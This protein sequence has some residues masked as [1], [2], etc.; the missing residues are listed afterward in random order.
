MQHIRVTALGLSALLLLASPTA[1]GA[2]RAD[3]SPAAG[4]PGD[5]VSAAAA[6]PKVAP[7]VTTTERDHRRK[8]RFE[9]LPPTD[10]QEPAR[11]A[12]AIRQLGDDLPVVAAANDL[13]AAE[14]RTT[15]REDT[16]LWVAPTGQLVVK[17]QVHRGEG[18]AP[19]ASPSAPL[20]Q[21][22]SLHSLPGS[23]HTL[24]LDFDGVGVT[25]GS[26]WAQYFDL[27]A[28]SY[29]GWDPMGD[30]PG[31]SADERA[32]IADIWTRVAEDYAPFDIDVTTADPG[33]AALVRNGADDT[34]FGT[35]LV[36]TDSTSAPAALC[37][38]G[39]GGVAL[40]GQVDRL[41]P[42]G[43][44]AWVF[45]GS[46]GQSPKG[47]AE[48]AS[49]EV[50]HTFG[51]AHDGLV[52]DGDTAAQDYYLGHGTWAPIMGAAYY[53]PVTQWSN[54]YYP[55][56][57]NNERDVDLIAAIAGRRTDEGGD[58]WDSPLRVPDTTAYITA[59][60][61]VDT[62]LVDDCTSGAHIAAAV[63]GGGAANLDVDLTVAH[64]G[65]SVVAHPNPLVSSVDTP[66]HWPWY[67]GATYVGKAAAGLD[68]EAAV[69]E[70]GP[71]VV[72]V[73]SSL[74]WTSDDGRTDY[75]TDGSL[76]AYRLVVQGCS[77]PDVAPSRPTG[78]TLTVSG[79]DLVASWGAPANT[80]GQP[81]TGYRVTLN[82]K[83]AVDLGADVT[84][85]TFPGAATRNSTV[86]VRAISA[87]G[88][89]GPASATSNPTTVP[90]QVTD[91]AVATEGVTCSGLRSIRVAWTSPA[92][93]GGSTITGY[94]LRQRD[95]DSWFKVFDLPST[96]RTERSE[97][98]FNPYPGEVYD[99]RIV[100]LNA[101]GEGE[102]YDFTALLKGKP[103]RITP[104][105]TTDRDART[106]TVD[107]AT[108]FD[109]GEPI[110][111]IFL[112]LT[113]GTFANP[114]TVTLP[115]GA[116][117]YTFTGV[118]TGHKHVLLAASNLWGPANATEYS[119]A[120]SDTSFDMPAISPFPDRV[121][122]I[123]IRVTSADRATGTLRVAW[124]PVVP[125]DPGHDPILWYDVCVDVPGGVHLPGDVDFGD[126]A[127]RGTDLCED[128][129]TLALTADATSTPHIDLTGLTV[130]DHL[131]SITPVNP[132]GPGYLSTMAT[133]DFKPTAITCPASYSSTNHQLR[134]EWEWFDTNVN[135]W[136]VRTRRAPETAWTVVSDSLPY[137]TTSIPISPGQWEVEVTA[138][139]RTGRTGAPV[140][141][142]V[143]VPDGPVTP[144]P[145]DPTPTD[146]TP[147]DPTP[148]TPDVPGQPP[149]V[150]PPTPPVVTPPT[151]PTGGTGTPAPP[152]VP[153]A[154]GRPTV[155]PGSKGGK[156]TVTVTWAA[157]RSAGSGP[158]TGYEVVVY[159]LK[160]GKPVVASR[161]TVTAGKRVAE[162]TLKAGSY[163][164]A[165][166]ARS[167]A[168]WG[169]T[170]SMSK[171][172][173]PR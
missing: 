99:Y 75:S 3:A 49:H 37:P 125:A 146:P 23:Q 133:L 36:I 52:A 91:V 157:P 154:P 94:E 101:N 7:A 126:G 137:Y 61:D 93:N 132:G 149:V 114:V 152:R 44:P 74:G 127:T 66:D 41:A 158:V 19:A 27:P 1:A 35:R 159:R 163:Q 145:T 135:Y 34:A 62:Y 141:C 16:T 13:T 21:A 80:G 14:L 69:P 129:T 30:G 86:A 112:T 104:T 100:A 117:T 18:F 103:T 134:W 144:T 130:G 10:L 167:A 123:S 120:Q 121:E 25:S 173:S 77:T 156:A 5:T 32:A 160:K 60:D 116:T 70:G 54:G 50:G 165:V 82:G 65:G 6:A 73:G 108:P 85:R 56:A 46:V 143:T 169:A 97:V 63:T 48:A 119:S 153:D 102:A 107:W 42:V 115:P 67:G 8:P 72:Q 84:T 98:C 31:F 113:T 57:D 131:V 111:R 172:F 151:A 164:V 138:H 29:E 171:A 106:V 68:A 110:Q 76:G 140:V 168:G 2:G 11:G 83:D 147:T 136:S 40:M 95:G 38:D 89:G 17:E 155:K 170:S 92:T 58:T 90:S 51:L 64:P 59:E 105:I 79:A 87:V 162:L 161:M 45:A 24:Y 109:G 71:Y 20:D 12:A 55:G 53:R 142:G 39:C 81:V 122:P 139:L 22:L 15:L 33:E 88:V 9:V 166:R 78:L 124:D 28:G 47:I 128:R 4:S 150:T 96:G 148:T 118:R 43:E 26:V